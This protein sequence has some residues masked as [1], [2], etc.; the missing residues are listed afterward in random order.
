MFTNLTKAIFG[1]EKEEIVPEKE[2]VR[3]DVA[4]YMSTEKIEE[5]YCCT[6]NEVTLYKLSPAPAHYTK[7]KQVKI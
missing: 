6:M 1:E 3:D 2:K 5:L 7:R 4:R